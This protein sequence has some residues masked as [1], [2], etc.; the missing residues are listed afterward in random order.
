MSNANEKTNSALGSTSNHP[1]SQRYETVKCPS[2][3]SAN[4]ID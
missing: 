4:R 3:Y 2:Q 1:I